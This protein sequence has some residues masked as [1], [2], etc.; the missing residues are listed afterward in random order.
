MASQEDG[1]S[2]DRARDGSPQL[3]AT[4]RRVGTVEPGAIVVKKKKKAKRSR[5][6]TPS[7]TESSSSS[8]SEDSESAAGEDSPERAKRRK[9]EIRQSQWEIGLTLW[10]L[11][12]RP[13]GLQN[14]RVV[15][16]WSVTK[17]L[18]C[19]AE[20]E[21]EMQKQGVGTAV[22]GRDMRR[23]PKKFKNVRDDGDVKLHAA[24]FERAP[25]S[26][27]EKHWDQI[28][29]K[30]EEL[31]RHVNMEHYGIQGRVEEAT[32]VKLHDRRVAVELDF[33][34]KK[35]LGGMGAENEVYRVQQV[36]EAVLNFVDIM[37]VLWP[38]D[39]GP[40]VI[41]RVLTE[42]R[43]AE[44]ILNGEAARIRLIRQ[45]FGEVGKENAGRAVRLEPPMSYANVRDA[46]KRMVEWLAPGTELSGAATRAAGAQPHG[47]RPGGGGG[48][49]GGPAGGAVARG[50]GAS[51]RG[52]GGGTSGSGGQRSASNVGGQ[53]ARIAPAIFFNR[54]AARLQ[55]VPVCY[56]YNSPQGCSRARGPTA[57][58]CV[59]A[60]GV[61]YAHACNY[62]V[63][64][65][66]AH[67]L[68]LHSRIGSH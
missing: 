49:G 33:F 67:C 62:F 54:S 15:E 57:G 20:L 46:W 21:K 1:S 34:L 7:T 40:H 35:G 65:T 12:A 36:Q 6:R 23:D 61:H 48:R 59:D 10:P 24:R 53:P 43:W 27:P 64:A 39:F 52:G 11:D 42:A 28:P 30:R 68:Q 16:T 56:S 60:N 22:F 51:G 26:K 3:R 32:I 18:K 37:Q 8:S 44:G 13:K 25:F 14:K 38:L 5:K 9:R 29:V 63:T 41:L 2:Q 66:G 50:G 45:F 19:K 31:F 4:G 55:G 58:T 17:L 47:V